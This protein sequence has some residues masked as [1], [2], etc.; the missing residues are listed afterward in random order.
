MSEFL[1]VLA[2]DVI[3][4]KDN[5]NHPTQDKKQRAFFSF[6]FEKQDSHGWSMTWSSCL[7]CVTRVPCPYSCPCGQKRRTTQKRNKIWLDNDELACLALH[8]EKEKRQE[9]NEKEYAK[10]YILLF[11][12]TLPTYHI[13]ILI[14]MS[15]PTFWS[16]IEVRHLHI[17][18]KVALFFFFFFTQDIFIEEQLY[19]AHEISFSPLLLLLCLCACCLS[20]PSFLPRSDLAIYFHRL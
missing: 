1:V 13:L 8:S 16:E 12:T 2:V 14:D 18:G 4:A 20:L 3:V 6:F 15:L 10:C 5:N 9:K 11:V 19:C 17:L 7:Q